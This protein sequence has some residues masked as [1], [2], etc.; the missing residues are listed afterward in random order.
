M[1]HYLNYKVYI[2]WPHPLVLEFVGVFFGR[3]FVEDSL[4]HQQLEPDHQLQLLFQVQQTF[5]ELNMMFYIYGIS[6]KYNNPS[7]ELDHLK[8]HI[9]IK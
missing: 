5:I 7:A 6:N 3:P 4:L 8:S 9:I 2:Y 1:Y